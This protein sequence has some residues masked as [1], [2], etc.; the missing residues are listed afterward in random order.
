MR[1][2]LLGLVSG[3]VACGTDPGE[4]TQPPPDATPKVT[5]YQDAAPIV[6]KH[7]MS[8]HQPGGIGPFS[9]V[10]YADA[11]QNAGLVI[12]QVTAKTMPPFYASE[13]PDCTPRFGW[14][15][16]PRLSDQEISTLNQWVQDGAVAGAVADVPIPPTT[17]LTGVTRTIAPTAA[18]TSMGDRDQFMCT[19]LDPQTGAGYWVTG[20]QVRPGTADVVHHV[21]VSEMQAGSDLDALVAAHGVGTPWDCSN[22]PTPSGFVM[23]IWTPGN[24][25]M[26]APAG[27]AIP[28]TQGAMIVMQIHY[29][30]AGG[31]HAPDITSI[32]LRTTLDW[33]QRMYLIT[34]FGNAPAAPQLLPDP[35]DRT[36]SPE[37]RIPADKADHVESMQFVVPDLGGLTDVR[38]YSVNPHMHLLGTHI[39]GQIQRATPTADQPASECLQNGDWDFDWQRTFIYNTDASHAPLVEAGDTLDIQCHWNNTIENPFEQRA[40]EDAGLV[41]PVD[42]GLGEGQSTD[43][44]CLEIFGLSIPAPA[45]PTSRQVPRLP[46]ALTSLDTRAALR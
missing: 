46:G 32:D 11:Q 3:L 21:V 40:L 38:L 33:P 28:V 44:M 12:Q 37:F 1:P 19:L 27:M 5:W 31:V 29:H 8:C 39:S 9:L 4:T 24:D 2:L 14:Q 7:C 23:N 43:E 42:V 20:L 10:D 34:A 15:D 17:A 18:F 30:P 36:S 26:Q 25:P 41:A 13:T 45:E 22:N 35:D 6:S 16:D